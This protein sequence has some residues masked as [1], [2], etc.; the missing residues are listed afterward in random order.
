MTRIKRWLCVLALLMGL[1]LA[2]AVPA[3]LGTGTSITYNFAAQASNKHKKNKKKKHK[4][5]NRKKSR[6]SWGKSKKNKQR[7]SKYKKQH[8]TDKS[9]RQDKPARKEKPRRYSSRPAAAA[10]VATPLASSTVTATG[11]ALWDIALPAGLGETT[12]TH[13]AIT[14]HYD[15]QLRI[16]ACV[17]YELTATMVDMSDAPGHETRK[18]YNYDADPAVKDS[19]NGGDYRGSGY[20]RGHM[21]P[22]MDMRWDKQTMRECFYMTNMCPQEAQLNNDD[23]RRM[24]ETV[25]RWGKQ[26]K[27]L[28]IHTGPIMGNSTATTSRGI[29]IPEAFYKIVYAP[30]QGRAIAFIY[31]NGPQPGAM[32]RYTTTIDEVERRTGIDF[33]VSLDDATE[34][35]IERQCDPT[36]WSLK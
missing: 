35:T 31:N 20:T 11:N 3:M 4:K 7:Y 10:A 18:N 36:S 14:I 12:I 28:I 21:A 8:R 29:A 6:K 30:A 22:A 17:T 23:W 25:H 24:E 19:P 2:D 9:A 15:R 13:K 33:F 34:S 1:V 5:K 16:P 26:Y 27:R 32:S